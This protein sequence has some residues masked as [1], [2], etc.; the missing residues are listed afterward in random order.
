M[1]AEE[2]ILIGKTLPEA[3]KLCPG[4]HFIVKESNGRFAEGVPR[5]VRARFTENAVEVV[6]S[7]F[8]ETV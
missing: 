1:S 8:K 5:I 2:D 6:T 3:L 4:K 7:R